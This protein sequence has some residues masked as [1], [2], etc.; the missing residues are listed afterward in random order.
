MSVSYSVHA[1]PWTLWEALTLH[2]TQPMKTKFTALAAHLATQ[3]AADLTA[4]ADEVNSFE[5]DVEAFDARVAAAKLRDERDQALDV[6]RYSS[7]DERDQAYANY[8]AA[9]TK[10]DVVHRISV[11]RNARE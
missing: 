5:A 3:L 8:C 4:Y 6:Y 10:Y 7:L 2:S 9:S 1:P 11:E